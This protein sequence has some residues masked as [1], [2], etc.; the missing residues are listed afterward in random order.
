MRNVCFFAGFM[1]LAPAV[2]ASAG[3]QCITDAR[4]VADAVYRQVLERPAGAEADAAAAQLT[5]GQRTV[6]E[7]MRDIAKTPEHQRRFAP[8]NANARANTAEALYRHILGRAADPSGLNATIE[9]L[10]TNRLD[11]IVDNLIDSEEYRNTYGEDTVPGS[12]V[13]Y[14]GAGGSAGVSSG[15]A[16]RMRFGNMDANRDGAIELAEWNGSRTSFN[17]HDWNRDGVLSGEE[18]RPGGRRAARAIEEDDFD[19]AGTTAWTADAFRRLDRNSDNRIGSNEWVYGAETFRRADRDRNG[20][21]SVAEFTDTS[22][23]DDRD[24]RF[25]NLDANRNGRVERREW[26]GS[27]DAFGWLD[28]N[29]DQVLSRAE[30]VGDAQTSSDPFANLDRNNNSTLT[31]DEWLWSRR[32][33]NRTDS[34]QDGVIS[35]REFNAAGGAPTANNRNQ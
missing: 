22:M 24:D 31:A 12:R 9:A 30:V 4:R 34:N 19:P 3:A 28:R 18:V 20:T 29:N 1:L 17:V 15:A 13:R 2:V 6:R 21:L 11:V 25:D 32:S 27:D 23:D 14:C 33:F 5:S 10:A 26:H 16:N 7:L 35:R 8:N